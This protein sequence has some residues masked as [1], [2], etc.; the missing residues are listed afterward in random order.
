MLHVILVYRSLY[1]ARTKDCRELRAA[2][3][4][5]ADFQIFEAVG[6]LVVV[7]NVDGQILYWNRAC[8]DLTGYSIEEVRGR[9][10][11]DFL[12]VPEEVESGK[13]VFAKLR[14]AEHP[15]RFA[16]YW[17]T[18]TCERRWLA[19]S[20]TLLMGPDGQVQY[21][22]GTGI[23]QTESKRTEEVLRASEA[24][25]SGLI[26]ISA[27]AI[28]SVDEEQRIVIYNEG[29]EKIFGWKTEEI[30]GQPLDVLLP[31]RLREVHRRSDNS[32]D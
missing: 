30:L 8:S 9:H 12:L 7:L 21:I 32:R 25:F 31:E 18:K 5:A 29:A 17:V 26:S 3:L 24:K 22:I 20:N 28:V 13:A 11:W 27:D 2:S 15:S 16:T 10:V 1:V 4:T 23:D 19:W 6:A 14:A